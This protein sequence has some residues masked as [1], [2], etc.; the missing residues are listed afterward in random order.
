MKPSSIARRGGAALRG[1]HRRAGYEPSTASQVNATLSG[2]RR[3]I[4]SAPAQKTAATAAIIAAMLSIA[5]WRRYAG[6][7]TGHCC[8]SGSRVRSAVASSWRWRWRIWCRSPT[9]SGSSSAAARPT[10]K[11]RGPRSP[12][13]G[14]A[15]CDRSKRWSAGSR[16]AG[17][18]RRLSRRV[19]GPN[20]LTAE[21]LRPPAAE[22]VKRLA[23]LAGFDPAVFAS[24]SLRSGYVTSAVEANANIM[25]ISEVT[26][27]KTVEMI[28]LLRRANLFHDPSGAAFL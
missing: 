6:S 2:I 27:H 28:H 7:G 19:I 13:R 26:R 14:A 15:S 20:R 8:C 23:S 18:P 3:T 16:S 5:T 10:R 25:K 9:G 12:C 17:S 21:P 24:H 4:G 11:G 22:I 1:A